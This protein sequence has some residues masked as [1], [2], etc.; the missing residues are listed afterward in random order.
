MIEKVIQIA[1]EAGE[2]IREGFGTDFSIEFKTSASNLVT[3]IDKKVR[4]CYY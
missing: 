2:I 4:T 1:K 3:E